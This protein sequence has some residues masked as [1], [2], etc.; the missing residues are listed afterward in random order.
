[1][2]LVGYCVIAQERCHGRVHIVG[3]DLQ[4]RCVVGI[5]TTSNN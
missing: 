1:M 4:P 3:F 5:V 2:R